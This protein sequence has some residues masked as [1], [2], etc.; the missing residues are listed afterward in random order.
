MNDSWSAPQITKLDFSEAGTDRRPL[1]PQ[2][3]DHPLHRAFSLTKTTPPGGWTGC[4]FIG[5]NSQVP[6]NL[7]THNRV[8][9]GVPNQP[10]VRL[11]LRPGN[12]Y[13]IHQPRSDLCQ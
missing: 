8:N 13:P 1:G 5:H 11:R 3:A 6:Q 4:P 10:Q 12:G 2:A 7:H 9:K